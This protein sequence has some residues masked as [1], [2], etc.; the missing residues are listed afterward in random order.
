M[1]ITI[2]DVSQE[3]SRCNGMASSRYF[4]AAGTLSASL[5]AELSVHSQGFA[6]AVSL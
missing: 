4:P 6:Q 5:P 2:S 3:T 1:A